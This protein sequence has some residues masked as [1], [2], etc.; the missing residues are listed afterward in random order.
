MR[1]KRPTV[2]DIAQDAGVSIATVSRFLNQDYSAMSDATKRRINEVVTERGYVNQKARAER[3]VA[4]VIPTLTDPFFAMTV[5]TVSDDLT[6]AGFSVQL[7]LTH[8]SLEEEQRIIRSLLIPA[9]AGIVYMSTVTSK[10]N[11][12]EML[13]AKGK[14]FV[15]LDSYL[16]EYNVPALAFSNGVYGM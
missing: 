2:R 10:E 5:E 7:C 4:V 8:D 14:P 1:E 6:A 12:Y 3:T 15:V 16:S 11:C 13:K 9:V